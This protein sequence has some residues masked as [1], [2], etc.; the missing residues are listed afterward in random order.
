MDEA[1]TLIAYQSEELRAK[2]DYI[3]AFETI[4]AA[5]GC[6]LLVAVVAIMYLVV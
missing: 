6:A 5:L 2:N 1:L 3:Q 4:S